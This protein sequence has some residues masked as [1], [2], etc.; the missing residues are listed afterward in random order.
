[1][2][3]DPKKWWP[4]KIGSHATLPH[5]LLL[6]HRDAVTLGSALAFKK[7]KA[8]SWR[9]DMAW[10]QLNGWFSHVLTP[11]AKSSAS[12][13]PA[14]LVWLFIGPMRLR[15]HAPRGQLDQSG[16]GMGTSA[17][18]HWLLVEPSYPSLLQQAL[19]KTRAVALGI[20]SNPWQITIWTI[21]W[22]TYSVSHSS[23]CTRTVPIFLLVGQLP[24]VVGCCE[25]IHDLSGY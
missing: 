5:A 17:V 23:F 11:K 2:I 15:L 18:L 25:H 14:A 20:E 1:M 22:L 21:L 10:T 4:S 13:L 19:L 24:F 16:T 6:C 9:L 8:W 12:K 3:A 7:D